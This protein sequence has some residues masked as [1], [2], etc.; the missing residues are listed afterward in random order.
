[1]KNMTRNTIIAKD[2]SRK[3][4]QTMLWAARSSEGE[5]RGRY[6][7]GPGGLDSET[8]EDS[9]ERWGKMC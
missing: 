8:A 4:A 5:I 7:T 9:R 3:H 2:R 1:M 6:G